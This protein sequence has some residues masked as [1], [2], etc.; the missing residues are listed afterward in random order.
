MK[1]CWQYCSFGKNYVYLGN[2]L[3]GMDIILE[4]RLTWLPIKGTIRLTES[5]TI[6]LACK[7]NISLGGIRV[8]KKWPMSTE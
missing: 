1:I 5:T 3:N 6:V 4:L 7:M 2:L 8:V